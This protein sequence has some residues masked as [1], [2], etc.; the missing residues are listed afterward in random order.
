[1][2]AE[3]HISRHVQAGNAMPAG[4][5]ARQTQIGKD[6]QKS[7]LLLRDIERPTATFLL[8]PRF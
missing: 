6:T 1:M 4:M 2:A 7:N 8:H 3:L 5:T